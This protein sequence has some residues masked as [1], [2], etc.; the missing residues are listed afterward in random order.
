MPVLI[1]GFGG[2]RKRETPGR[3]SFG[4]PEKTIGEF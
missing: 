4:R 3:T 1:I 2:T